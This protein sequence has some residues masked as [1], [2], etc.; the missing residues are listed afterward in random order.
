MRIPALYHWSITAYQAA[1]KLSALFNPKARKWVEGRQ[2]WRQRLRT[3]MNTS[4]LPEQPRCWIHVASLGEF[5]QGRPLIEALKT[6][7]PDL[8]IL[9][10]F[11]SPSG[12][13]IRQHYPLVDGV[14]YLPADTPA[15]PPTAA[16]VSAS[17][18]TP[19]FPVTS[20]RAVHITALCAS[21]SSKSTLTFE[22][23]NG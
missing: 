19:V 8:Q 22:S 11:F 5:E 4:F 13:E 15:R 14:C 20:T 6:Q 18:S 9:L 10:S 7:Y 3:L 12:Y 1:I 2:N 23:I 21:C 16:A 17:I